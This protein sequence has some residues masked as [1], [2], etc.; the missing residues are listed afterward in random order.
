MLASPEVDAAH[1]V[2]AANL[3]RHAGGDDAALMQDGDLVR[4]REHDLHVVLGEEQGQVALL[5]DAVEQRDLSCVSCA[6]MPAVGSSSS[7]MRGLPA[8]AMPS[9][10]CFCAPWLSLAGDRAGDVLQRQLPDHLLGLAAEQAFRHAH[11]S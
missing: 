1:L 2:V 9:S 7:S 3:V 6:L 5:G 8:S 10:T 4:D 11:M